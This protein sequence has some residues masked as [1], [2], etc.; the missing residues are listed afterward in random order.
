MGARDGAQYRPQRIVQ[1]TRSPERSH[2]G[3]LIDLHDED[4]H[5]VASSPVK[6]CRDGIAQD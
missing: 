1:A 6:G 4:M 2:I 5:E 3:D